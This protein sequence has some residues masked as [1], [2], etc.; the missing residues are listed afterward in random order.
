MSALPN[1]I[2]AA[3]REAIIE[4][5][6]NTAVRDA[7]TGARD[8]S[9]T[10][11]EGFFDL[12]ADAKKIVD[13]RGLM[14][15]GDPRFSVSVAALVW[16]DPAMATPAVRL[17]DAEQSVDARLC[18]SRIELDL[19]DEVTSFEL[20]YAP[21]VDQTPPPT[22]PAPMRI[23]PGGAGSW[24]GDSWENAAPLST[25]NS[26]IARAK[27]RGAEVWLRADAG[28][29]RQDATLTLTNGDTTVRGVDVN[30]NDMLAEIIGSRMVDTSGTRLWNAKADTAA[31]VY[32][33][34]VFRLNSGCNN[35]TFKFLHFRNQGRGCIRARQAL[36]NLAVTNC[37]GTNVAAFLTNDAA[38]GAGTPTV[39]KL[40]MRDCEVRGFSKFAVKLEVGDSN[41]ILI[42]DFVFDA[43]RQDGDNFASGIVFDGTAHNIIIR[44]GEI[45]N[46]I[47]SVNT[48]QNGDG[49]AGERGNRDI[50]VEDVTITHC[51]DGGVDFKGDNIVM[52]R[53]NILYCHRNYRLWGYAVLE[54]CYGLE[55]G[56]NAGFNKYAK[57]NVS[58]F[59]FGM[60]RLIRGTYTQVTGKQSVIRVEKGGMVSVSPSTVINKPADGSVYYVEPVTGTNPPGAYLV[61]NPNDR[62]PPVI[63]SALDLSL[64]ENKFGIFPITTDKPAQLRIVG[65]PAAK[66]F[67]TYGTQL[68]LTRRD[69]E[70]PAPE[71]PDNIYRVDIQVMD[72]NGNLSVVR[73][74]NVTINNVDDDPITPAILRDQFAV[75]KGAYSVIR[76][77]ICW[78]DTTRTI[79]ALVDTKVAL[80]DDEFG[81]GTTAFQD[82]PDQQAFLRQIGG[83]YFLEMTGAERY[84]IGAAGY[85]NFPEVTASFM[86]RRGDDDSDFRVLF[87]NPRNVAA[88][89]S[90]NYRW[91]ITVTG[92]QSFT[93]VINSSNNTASTTKATVGADKVLSM[94]S[95][96]R[97]GR[98]NA[99][100]MFPAS[101][102]ADTTMTYSATAQAY[103]GGSYTGDQNMYGRLYGWVISNVTLDPGTALF[104]VERQLTE[105]AAFQL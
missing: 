77:E 75:T 63:T 34:E 93:A 12:L 61:T 32:G 82:D 24:S 79:P 3:T 65:G 71:A 96:T 80:I 68:R 27:A 8:G 90:S 2:A 105:A 43:E 62:T 60:V 40:T 67:A 17:V 50:L 13:E 47:D 38:S 59:D 11:G 103:V 76:P 87:T 66:Y 55:P 42:E 30:G 36:S 33:K 21:D 73:R 88:T 46:I 104:R 70:T 97:S 78:Q 35:L 29:Y 14:L 5:Y 58:V 83:V 9:L 48:Y 94:Q 102:V 56:D 31:G 20:F 99:E 84:A 72:G 89:T 22:G 51:T 91:G 25:L 26:M 19:E 37:N 10:P 15:A 54:D 86:I 28:P 64:N 92:G 18:C 98:S 100:Q 45:H 101:P 1:D 52:R 39:S 81:F 57:A 6:E 7:L 41:D 53:V 49:I 95:K 85:F 69:Y 74:A 44:R 4:R 23:A 16:S